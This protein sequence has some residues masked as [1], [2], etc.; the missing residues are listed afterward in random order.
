MGIGTIGN[1][2][3]LLGRIFDT[4]KVR[5]PVIE[6]TSKKPA[7]PC[8]PAAA[9][10]PRALPETEGVDSDH[11]A[12]FL[13]EIAR[14]ETLHM[15][16][17]L[18]LRHGQ[19]LS[20]A[21]FGEHDLRLWKQT[22]SACKSITAL[23]VGLCI[24]E[25]FFTLE[26]K[27]SNLFEDRLS[28]LSRLSLKD[29][30]L[31]HLLTMTTGASFNEVSSA[32]EEDWAKGFLSGSFAPGAFSYNSL[33]TYMLSVLI[34]EKTGESLSDF[35][36]SRLFSPLGITDF[37]WETCPKGFE[38]GGWGLYLRPE[39]MAKIGLLVLNGG[40]WNGHK[41]LPKG[42]VNAATHTQTKT[43]G[44]S[45]L[46][47]YG[48]QI[49]T[50]R[51][52]DTFLFN[53]MLGQNV[54]GFRKSDILL[55]S[56]AG[57][58]EMFQTGHYFTTAHRYFDRAFPNTLPG[59]PTAQKRLFQTLEGLR[60]KPL[61]PPAKR[62]RLSFLTAKKEAASTPPLPKECELLDGMCFETADPHAKGASLLPLVLQVTQNNY[63][64]GLS[65][66]RFQ[67][68]GGVF[69][70]T[71]AEDHATHL[72]PIGFGQSAD[73]DLLFGGVP[74]RVKTLGSFVKDEDERSLLKIRISFPETPTT[75]Y[76]KLYYKTAFPYVKCSE[77]PGGDFVYRMAM[78]VK[79]TL[80]LTPVIG[81]TVDKIDDDFLKFRIDQAFSPKI[82]LSRLE[83]SPKSS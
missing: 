45:E 80:E 57:N 46:F 49:W 65:S 2:L 32:A 30:T 83:N 51:D 62:R 6:Y 14:D 10:L 3:T 27:L 53:G 15:H 66:L 17:I 42:F 34:Q 68:S 41:I 74:Y 55:V 61:S 82:T 12:A 21:T 40:V 71:Y 16:S 36:R 69:Y 76:L 81:G 54:L 58:D 44:V 43:G 72:L 19:I 4:Q 47:D 33:N 25:G 78:H 35:L 24:E 63:G 9:P 26:D 73:V 31:R 56:N 75:R 1:S 67:C 38:K 59:N 37:F 23:A 60:E 29:L 79:H 70:M 20:E 39:D 7:C 5:T 64:S 48:Y 13:R 50:G 22:F 18:V 28:P 77:T 11:I 52:S 8:T